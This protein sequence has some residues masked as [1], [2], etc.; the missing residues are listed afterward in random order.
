MTMLGAAKRFGEALP[1]LARVDRVARWAHRRRTLV[2]AYHNVVPAGDRLPGDRSLHLPQGAFAAQLD[3]LLATHDVIPLS[4]LY[5][6]PRGGRPRVAI[7][8]DDAYRGAISLGV[9]EVE[10]RGIPATVFVAPGL[11]GAT[12]WWDRLADQRTGAVAPEIRAAALTMHMGRA[13][14]VMAAFGPGVTSLP[15]WA[16]IATSD[17]VR[18]AA[19]K[20]GITL[21]AHTWSHPNLTR[22]EPADL[23]EELERPLVWLSDLGRRAIPWL[24]FPYGLTSPAVA[25]AAAAAGYT[26]ALRIDGG[27]LPAASA[28]HDLRF[29]LPRLNVPS[30]LS[31][32]GFRLRAAGLL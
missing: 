29:D 18:E 23:A 12:T 4:A 6:E 9:A 16:G 1:L 24:A 2:L 7:T 17:E 31:L 10:K 3:A 30:G 28:A 26:G 22:L 11:L 5:E 21:G 25:R 15:S 19:A 27:W 13:E 14:R 8:F 20:P 32:A